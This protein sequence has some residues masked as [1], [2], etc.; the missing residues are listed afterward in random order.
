[1]S[2]SR[3]NSIALAA[4]ADETA[5]LIRRARTD[6]DRHITYDP[7]RRPGVAGLLSLAALCLERDP[8][9]VAEEIGAAGASALKRVAN[10]AVNE[11]FAPLRARRA[12]YQQDRELLRRVLREGNER[13]NAVAART[14]REV[15]EAMNALY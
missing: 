15:R 1:M 4:T 12:A 3:G 10:E 2:K 13:A 9:E 5:A 6:T 7:D 14:L 8:R 11:Y